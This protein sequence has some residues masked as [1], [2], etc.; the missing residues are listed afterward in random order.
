MS[1][2]LPR[3]ANSLNSDKNF[4]ALIFKFFNDSK[5]KYFYF[6]SLYLRKFFS[7]ITNIQKYVKQ[8]GYR[9]KD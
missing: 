8:L 6:F 3:M 1:T 7:I 9:F 4:I 2:T 5:I